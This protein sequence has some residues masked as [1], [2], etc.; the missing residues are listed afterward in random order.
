MNNLDYLKKM[1]EGDYREYVELNNL[2]FRNTIALEI[3]AEE[4]CKMNIEG[5]S[6]RKIIQNGE[7]KI[8]IKK[9]QEEA[10]K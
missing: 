9:L 10:I 7:A 2:E 5:Y 4:L 8:L 3:I 1:G 6:L